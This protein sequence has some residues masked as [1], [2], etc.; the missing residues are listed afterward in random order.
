MTPEPSPRS[1]SNHN[2]PG[3]SFKGSTSSLASSSDGMTLRRKKKK[4]PP[5]PATAI[6]NGEVKVSQKRLLL[7]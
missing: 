3:H 5:P 1:L 7:N 4:A 2:S 6:I